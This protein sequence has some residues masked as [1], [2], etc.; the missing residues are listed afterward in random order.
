MSLFQ[1]Y[2]Q[3]NLCGLIVT[4]TSDVCSLYSAGGLSEF[5]TMA[6]T[7]ACP[8]GKSSFYRRGGCVLW[9]CF[10]WCRPLSVDRRKVTLGRQ[11][12]GCEV[13]CTVQLCR[14]MRT[15]TSAESDG[16]RGA[17]TEPNPPK[18]IA[19]EVKVRLFTGMA[20]GERPNTSA[21]LQCTGSVLC[22]R[23]PV[24]VIR[25]NWFAHASTC[26]RTYAYEETLLQC[27][28]DSNDVFQNTAYSVIN[29]ILMWF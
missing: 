27:C 25:F 23:C 12:T 11:R 6:D 7:V 18:A 9:P 28:G 16:S 2:Y 15:K 20:T 19:P 14:R 4:I 13:R 17:R 1:H 5:L 29:I 24:M 21:C 26:I 3:R 22:S 8:Q 10:S